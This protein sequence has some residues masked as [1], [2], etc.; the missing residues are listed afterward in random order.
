MSTPT[1][2][3]H[4]QKVRSIAGS[5][6]HLL[7]LLPGLRAL[8]YAPAMLVLADK[9]DRP[10]PF[11]ERMRAA[12][13]PTDIVPMR[14][15]FDPLV[16]AR[17]TRRLR[18]E[19]WDIVHTHLIHAGFYGR[20]AGRRIKTPIVSSYHNLGS[21][22]LKPGIRQLE[23][24]T[25]RWCDQIICISRAARDFVHRS[26]G[27]AADNLNVVHYGIEATSSSEDAPFR[28]EL[29]I[30][31]DAPLVGVVGRL[32]DGKGHVDLLHAFRTLIERVPSARLAIIGDGPER[33]AL[34]RLTSTLA[35]DA[36][37]HF[38]GYRADAATL[39][40]SFDV[41][42]LPSWSEG[43]GLVVLEAMAAAKPVVAT[44]VGALPEIVVDGVTGSLVPPHD[45]SA[46]A[47]ALHDLIAQPERARAMGQR[48]RARF[49]QHFTLGQML[50]GTSAVYQRVV[51][52]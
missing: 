18:Q 38:L 6:T 14:F 36:Y 39:M 9:D 21:L 34:E 7:A 41:F 15:D 24:R 20:I 29:G 8:G 31:P 26:I 19:R 30:T 4:I 23:R 11:V 49:E 12:G 45:P 2:L 50:D 10:Q 48:G 46:L 35:L 13:V 44:D 25:A 28:A 1:K 27:V 22:Y 42:V 3:L 17:V 47:T 52:R 33:A 16:L 32:I 51:R 37:V 43:F 40:H 5:E